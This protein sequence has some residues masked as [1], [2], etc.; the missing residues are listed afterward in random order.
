MKSLGHLVQIDGRD[1][2]IE[3]TELTPEQVRLPGPDGHPLFRWGSPAMMYWSVGF[4]DQLAQKGHKLAVASLFQAV[5][6]MGQW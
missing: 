2:I 3:Y 5:E 1:H 4:F 6:S